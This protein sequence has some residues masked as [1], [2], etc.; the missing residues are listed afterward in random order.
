MVEVMSASVRFD[1]VARRLIFP[2]KYQFASIRSGVNESANTVRRTW[3]DSM[4]AIIA[5]RVTDAAVEPISI[6]IT[7]HG[8]RLS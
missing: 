3:R 7:P 2:S 8:S 1:F 4:I 6:S 5:V